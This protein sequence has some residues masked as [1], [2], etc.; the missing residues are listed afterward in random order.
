MISIEIQKNACQWP[1]TEVLYDWCEKALNAAIKELSLQNINSELSVVFIDDASIKS[2]NARWRH[3]DKATNVLSFPTKSLKIGEQPGPFLG[4]IILAYETIKQEALLA[5]KTFEEHVIHLF[6][7]GFL[8]LLGYEHEC[9]EDAC[10]Q[11]HCERDILRHLSI[12]D[13]YKIRE[14]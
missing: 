2:L 5:H 10:V 1:S 9:E 12:E 14:L 6:I 8:H 7:H 13:P 4:D 3:K 11:E